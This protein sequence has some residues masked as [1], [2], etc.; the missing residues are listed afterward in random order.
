MTNFSVYDVLILQEYFKNKKEPTKQDK[1]R[2]IK[3][4]ECLCNLVD[5]I[6]QFESKVK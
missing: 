4:D 3:L 5:N 6:Q 2:A 1:E